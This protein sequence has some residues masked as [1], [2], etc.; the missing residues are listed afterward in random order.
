MERCRG[1]YRGKSLAFL[2][3]TTALILTGLHSLSIAG[4]SVSTKPHSTEA[5]GRRDA[6]LFSLSSSYTVLFPLLC[7]ARK[8]SCLS[9][10]SL[11]EAKSLWHTL[12]EPLHCSKE[13][14][15]F[16][17]IKIIQF[18]IFCLWQC[19]WPHN[20]I[21]WW[22]LR[23]GTTGTLYDLTTVHC[24]CDQI[25]VGCPSF[26]RKHL[27]FTPFHFMVKSVLCRNVSFQ[28]K[29]AHQSLSLYED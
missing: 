11:R 10:F 26:S 25:Y 14:E 6:S 21:V 7:I 19:W 29:D 3:W 8:P 27:K 28:I 18:D 5:A 13:H 12:T 9:L 15:E 2:P 1:A 4:W 17:L 24:P 20:A 16:F 23:E 22:V